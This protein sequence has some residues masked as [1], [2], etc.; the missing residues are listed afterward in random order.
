[1]W[2]REIEEGDCGKMAFSR[3][4]KLGDPGF[5]SVIGQEWLNPMQLDISVLK[6]VKGKKDKK[7]WV[8]PAIQKILEKSGKPFGDVISIEDQDV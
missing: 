3:E 5:E 4:S 6:A 2:R 1:M 7:R 8:S